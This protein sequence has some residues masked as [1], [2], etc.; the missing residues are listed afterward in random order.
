MEEK[1]ESENKDE[2]K[3]NK[4]LEIKIEPEIKIIERLDCESFHCK[5]ICKHCQLCITHDKC[6]CQY[7]ILCGFCSTNAKLE[8]KKRSNRGTNCNE[9]IKN[10]KCHE[11]N[12]KVLEYKFYKIK[13]K[14]HVTIKKDCSTDFKGLSWILRHDLKRKRNEDGSVNLCDIAEYN[15]NQM[16]SAYEYD[17]KNRYIL[18][19]KSISSIQGH[20]KDLKIDRPYMPYQD[21]FCY[22]VTTNDNAK[23]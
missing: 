8:G 19:E 7:V 6:K 11:C 1:N 16:I 20:N 9:C 10:K 13:K 14:S 22:H 21:E 4:K 15:R 2:F 18:N 12:I 5:N 23:K 3:N 17:E